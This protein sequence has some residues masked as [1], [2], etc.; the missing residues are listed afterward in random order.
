[1]A[2]QMSNFGLVFS[3]VTGSAPGHSSAAVQLYASGA[4]NESSTTQLY[5][6]DSAGTEYVVG[7]SWKLEDGDGTELAISG[8]A[9]V[10]FVD[11]AG[12]NGLDVNW[13]DVSHGIDGD[14][15]DLTFK[16]DIASLAATTTVNDAD[17]V[18]ID[19][20]AGGTLRKMTR[21]H[22]IESAAL[23][24]INI[25]GGAIDGTPIGA[26]SAAAG[27][28]AAIIGTSAVINGNAAVSGTL[29]ATGNTQLQGTLETVGAASFEAAITAQ[30]NLTVAGVTALNGNVDLGDATGDTITATGRFDSDLVPS[31][32][33][34]RDLGTSAL[35]WAEAHIDHGHIDTITATGTSTLT[36]VDINGGA[37]DGTAIG[38]ASPSTVVATTVTVN[39]RLVPDSSGGADIGSATLEWGDVYIADDKGVI[40][41]S[42]QNV[43]LEY[44]ED[45]TDT[46]LI[47]GG[48]VTLA[49]DKKLYFG[50]GKDASIEYD[51]DGTDELKFSG[52]AVAFD[53]AVSFDANVTLGNASSDVTTVTGKL[54]GSNGLYVAGATSLG[55][56]LI[57][58]DLEVQGVVNTV[59]NHETELHI[60]DKV[61]LIGSGTSKNDGAAALGALDAAG[62][63]LGSTGSLAVASIQWDH[64]EDRWHTPEALHVSGAMQVDGAAVLNGNVDLGNA[65]SDTI[66]ATGRFDSNL[67]PSSDDARDLGTSDL[68]WKDLHLD[69]VAYIDDLRADALGAAMNCASQAMTN[70]NVD[71]GVLDGVTL[72][73]NAQVTITDADMN[74]G[75]IDGTPIGAASPST[76]VGTTVTVNTALLPDSS[77]GADL[78]STSAEWGDL[79]IAD[80]KK[81]YFGSGQDASFEYDEDGTDTLLYAGASM[82]FSDDTKLEFGTGGDASFEYD[83]NGNDVLLYAGANMRF[84]DDIKLEFGAG[85]DASFEYDENGND[86]LLYAGANMR[87]GDDIKLEFGA[88]GDATIEYDEDGTD[89]LRFAGAAVTFEQA[90][91]MDANVT[92][93]NAAS[94]ITTVTG[95]LSGSNGMAISGDAVVIGTTSLSGTV[96]FVGG[97][98]ANGDA[99]MSFN[100]SN[101][102]LTSR[103]AFTADGGL[104]TAANGS[105]TGALT[106]GGGYGSSGA[107]ISSAGALQLNAGLTVDD[108]ATFGGGYGS[109]GV[110]ISNAGNIQANGALTVDTTLSVGG[111]YSDGGSGL[112]VTAAG[113]LSMNGALTAGSDGEGVDFKVH[114]GA[115]NEFMMYDASENLLQMNNSS[116]ATILSIGGDAS[117]EYA[118][119]VTDGANNQNRIRAAAFVTYSDENL[120]TNVAR[121]D[122]ALDTVMKLEGVNFNW[123]KDNSQDLGFIAQDVQ[124]VVPAIVH[125]DGGGTHGIDY[126]RLTA[127][128]VEAVKEQQTTIS[129]LKAA[130]AVLTKKIND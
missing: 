30:N 18:M 112:S 88:G 31:T 20:G 47:S 110:S 72:G 127:V 61:V 37:I 96:A 68:Q 114:G 116:G 16:V 57:R 101:G 32:D 95:K 14:E 124:R 24:N 77:G 2:T 56:T 52:A 121:M 86:V 55:N 23:D 91:S 109:T 123:K 34:A 105:I 44:D 119:D 107:T 118:I 117:S 54:S 100:A 115:A 53:Q 19:D 108:A 17:L 71:S 22:F 125:S 38:A 58:G 43:K 126:S 98:T 27:T 103:G 66:T 60:A 25:D 113:A 81:I 102:N 29:H 128:L 104:S 28:F 36:T 7:G 80:D 130:M 89:E 49:D 67:V 65:T 33:S 48:D 106:V 75:S 70:I 6:K 87:F 85:G 99:G 46:L 35:Q 92:L 74:G 73:G 8:G 11:G 41:G 129:E 4:A 5:M 26:N 9:Q 94:D 63:F 39:T 93:G 50:T 1:M 122:N 82:R 62:L 10:K 51:E 15:Y 83:E 78:G 3:Q 59:A 84:G 64:S 40:F 12:A 42:D 76:I 13:S 21:A 79:Y 90:V 111:G 97:Y 69:G 120:K 45:G